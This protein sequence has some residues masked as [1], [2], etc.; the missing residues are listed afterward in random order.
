MEF[1]AKEA[2]KMTLEASSTQKSE[3]FY[4]NIL[5]KIVTAAQ[6]GE[7]FIYLH[8]KEYD[9]STLLR[10]HLDGYEIIS[11]PYYVCIRW[12]V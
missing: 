5:S 4:D 6:K 3:E 1:T 11:D 7:S 10:L 9:R 2:L 12:G 8:F